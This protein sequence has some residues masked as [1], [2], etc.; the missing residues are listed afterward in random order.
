MRIKKDHSAT[1]LSA[2]FARAKQKGKK[3]KKLRKQKRKKP[4]HRAGQGEA[5]I[6][7]GRKNTLRQML[8]SKSLHKADASEYR[9]DHGFG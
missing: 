4:R 6:F 9:S 1:S 3:I 7:L 2:L 5:G 8:V